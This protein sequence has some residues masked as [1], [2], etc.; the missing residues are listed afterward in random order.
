[1]DLLT[2]AEV[3]HDADTIEE[4]ILAI[5]DRLDI[6]GEPFRRAR[7]VRARNEL[8][9]ELGLLVERALGRPPA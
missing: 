8:N 4:L 1:M 9:T 6:V 5:D 7:L 2:T 3:R